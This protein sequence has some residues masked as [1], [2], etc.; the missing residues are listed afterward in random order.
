MARRFRLAL[1]RHGIE[2][3]A[4]EQSRR[5]SCSD[6]APTGLC[7]LSRGERVGVRAYGLSIDITPH[8]ASRRPLSMGEVANRY[9]RITAWRSIL[10]VPVFGNSSMNL[11]SRG[12]L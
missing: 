5:S 2:G 11:I 7:S 12:Y 6:V 3:I 1:R 9:I 8:P 4:I 10:P